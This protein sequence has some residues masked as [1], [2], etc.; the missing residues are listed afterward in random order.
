MHDVHAWRLG[1]AGF[2]LLVLVI[3]TEVALS[4]DL[5]ALALHG[6]PLGLPGN[7]ECCSPGSAA[8]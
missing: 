6:R 7:S 5:S 2:D 8:Q 4:P 1:I 3:L